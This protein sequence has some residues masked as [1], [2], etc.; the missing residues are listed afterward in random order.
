[1]A[2]TDTADELARID[3]VI[4]RGPFDDTWESLRGFEPP[5]WF[6]QAKFGIFVHWGAYAVPAHRTEWYARLMYREG[7]AEH[8]HHRETWGELTEFGYKDFLPKLDFANFDADAMVATFRRAGARFVVP[9]AEHH[10]GFTMYDEPRTRWKAPLIGPKRDPFGELADA[11]RNQSLVVGA[12]SHRAE[13]WFFY[14]SG[15]GT[16]SDLQDP[17]WSDLYGPAARQEVHP[18]PEFLEDWLIRTTHIIDQYR[19]QL[20][21]FDW[22][23]ESPGF[24]PY[25]RKIAAYY[26]NRAAEWGRGVV[27]HYK[28]D[29]FPAGTAV[30]DVERGGS[31]GIRSRPWQNDTSVS[32]NAWGYIDGH[33][34]KQPREL[35]SDLVD[36]V[37][38]NGCLLL[39]VGPKADG[40]LPE[41]EVRLLEQVGAWLARNG[42]GIYGTSPWTVYGEGPGSS[43]SGSFTDGT[44]FE[45]GTEDLRFTYRTNTDVD[46]LYVLSV[47][48]AGHDVAV[49]TLS[50]DTKLLEDH[51][52]T[53]QLLGTMEHLEHTRDRDALR[54]RLPQHVDPG[55]GFGLR[56][57]LTKPPRPQRRDY[58]HNA[59]TP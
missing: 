10:D 9:V 3:E 26:Y 54:V 55:D 11:C 17:R 28:Y 52:E 37:S 18:D 36:V 41:E 29:A 45:L 19:P 12:S 13:N 14:N 40:T 44:P 20:L 30:F 33:D 49:R 24:E 57:T 1:M 53:V 32:R 58:L 8:A 34:Y 59:T 43:L 23:I 5:E 46:Y 2:I 21:W 51:I 50:A 39:N 7:S 35:L 42:E 56:I 47:Q 27:L 38:K 25:L 31:S 48:A 15:R 4:R 16:A 6:T 22:W